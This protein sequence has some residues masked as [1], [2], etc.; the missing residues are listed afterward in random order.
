MK[1]MNGNCLNERNDCLLVIFSLAC[2][3]IAPTWS[4]DSEGADK[5]DST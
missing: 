5:A 3:Q 1:K 2:L 4:Q